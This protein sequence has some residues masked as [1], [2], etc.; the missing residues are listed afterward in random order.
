M[1]LGA[2]ALGQFLVSLDSSVAT[3]ALPEIQSDFDASASQLQWIVIGYLVAG[4]AFALPIGAAG[5]R[6][7]RK[8]LYVAGAA[9]FALGSLASAL[10]PGIDFL[11]AARFVQGAGAAA[12]S[13]LALA[14]LTAAVPRTDIARIVGIWTAV[15]TAAAAAGPLVGGLLVDSF[16]W[17]AVFAVNVPVALLVVFVAQ[18]DLREQVVDRR[19]G[20]GWLGAGLLALT[21]ILVTVGLGASESDGILSAAALVPILGG[22][23]F[24]VITVI[25][26]RRS[27]R[28]LLD[29]AG[30]ARAPIP[31]ALL[32]SLLLGMTLSGALY[33][34]TIM[35]QSVLGYSATTTGVV[36]MAATLALVVASASSGR[37][38]SRFGIAPVA[39]LG[40]LV[41]A[42]GMAV[43]T[44]LGLETPPWVVAAQLVIL[45]AGVGIAYPAVNAAA[46][47]TA[48]REASGSAAGAL[49]VAAQI[50]A[51]L[52]VA[53]IGGLTVDRIGA[54]WDQDAAG[55]ASLTAL[56]GDVVVGDVD[57]VRSAAGDQAADEAAAAFLDGVSEAFVVSAGGLLVAS[58]FAAGG[59]RVRHRGQEDHEGESSSDHAPA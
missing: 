12:L 17:R 26:Q 56:R 30:L 36:L 41:A 24:L 7:G 21:L 27:D 13:A 59:L 23:V 20:V 58:V 50:A 47:A 42:A 29:W 52:G 22:V 28:P 44:T 53:L 31:I 37:V 51:V 4:A 32:L 46:M 11:V 39:T 55:D 8:K 19:A 35:L 6:L 45:G 49:S 38:A 3:V 10:A 57:D 9:L 33:E 2:L 16:G 54:Q 15:A 5:D 40:F 43:L 34:L 48:G 18:R 14:M 25:Q 1:V